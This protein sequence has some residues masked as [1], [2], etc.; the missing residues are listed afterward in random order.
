MKFDASLSTLSWP[1][2]YLNIRVLVSTDRLVAFR[3]TIG[4]E[5]S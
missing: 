4:D 3:A 2:K 5:V 1:K